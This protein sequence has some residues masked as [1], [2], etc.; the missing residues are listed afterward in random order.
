MGERN[1]LP[2]IAADIIYEG[3]AVGDNGAG[4]MRP[5]VAGDPFRGFAET[6]VD[7]SA[8]AAGDKKVRLI[9]EGL[10]K[11]SVS[12]AVITDVGQPVYASDDDTFVFT[13]TGNSFIGFVYRYVSSGVVIVEFDTN[14]LLD[15]YAGKTMAT[16]I[17]NTTLD[18]TY[19][20]KALWVT[21]DAK[22]MTMPA[23]EGMSG[24]MFINGGAFGTIALTVSP[25]AADMI[26]GPGITGA[27]DK[28]IVNTKA[29]ANRGD[30]IVIDYGDANGW[31]ITKKKG[32]WAR[33][34]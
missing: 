25:N 19:S 10:V 13:P 30:L 28:D 26:E 1:E 2:V 32:T 34:A 22:T 6:I 7:N 20:G 21:V 17:D 15:P 29:T 3:A 8:G 4:Y 23:V 31:V 11:L 5:L 27:D 24:I 14:D 18:A 33:Q 9:E 12:G 16:V